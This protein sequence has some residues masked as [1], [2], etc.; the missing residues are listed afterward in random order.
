[1]K[2]K[3]FI[4]LT[5]IA[6]PVSLFA[7]YTEDALRFSQTEQGTSSRIK[8]LGGAQTAVGGDLSSLASNPAGLGLFTKSEFNF[9]PE[10]SNNSAHSKYLNN[11]VIADQS[12]AGVNQLGLVIYSPKRRYKGQDVNRGLISVNFGAS[13]NKTNNF[14]AAVDYS[15]VN[16]RS[17]FADYLADLSNNY[18]ANGDPATNSS[19]LPAG[20]LE[21]MGYNNFLTEY[22]SSGYFPT[23]SLN[24]SQRNQVYHSG[25]QTEVNFGL[26]SNFSNELYLGASLGLSSLH[27]EADREYSEAGNNQSYAGQDPDF[28]GGKYDLLFRSNQVTE[29]SGINLKLGL[30]YR[31]APGVRFGLSF[32]SPTWYTITDTYSEALDT[33]YTRSNG[34]AILPAYTNNDEIYDTDYSLRT[35][36]KT[37]AGLAVTMNNMALLTGDLEYVDY[38]SIKFGNSDY[39]LERSTTRDIRDRYKAAVNYKLGGELKLNPVSLRIGYNRTGNPYRHTEYSQNTYSGGVGYRSKNLY[40]DLTYARSAYN[41][42]SRPYIISSTYNDFS[43][44]G[45]GEAADI[46][47]QRDNVYATIGFRF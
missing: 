32:I 36:Y 17:S 39:D 30:I 5:G 34:T 44:T 11:S 7:Q 14:N 40:I 23:T 21:K 46:K 27:Y 8:A 45:S 42:T 35:P 4:L 10:F 3:I 18:L 2:L 47:N 31:A 6:L 22:N 15:G 9:T 19:A 13:V 41:T 33:R 29:G 43:V 38:S 24:N 12:K 1:M 25:S 16:P 28:T 20:S 26:A 37:T